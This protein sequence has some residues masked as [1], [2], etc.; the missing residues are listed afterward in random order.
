MANYTEK[1]FLEKGYT[2]KV[3]ANGRTINGDTVHYYESKE[4]AKAEAD[5]LRKC[6]MKASLLQ[7][8]KKFTVWYKKPV[9]EVEV[10]EESAEKVWTL[11]SEVAECFNGSVITTDLSKW[12]KNEKVTFVIDGKEIVRKIYDDKDV[13]LCTFIKGIEICYNYFE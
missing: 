1:D 2:V 4:T 6:G 13:G 8:G 11:K 9:E 10:A 7:K 3:M 12:F 5:R